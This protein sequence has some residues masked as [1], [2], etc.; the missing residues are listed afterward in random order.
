MKKIIPG[1][2]LAATLLLAACDT[3][4]TSSESSVPSSSSDSSSSLV[5]SSTSEDE[6]DPITITG[7]TTLLVGDTGT[8]T[9]DSTE[10]GL[11]WESSAP[12][13]VSVE[14][15]GAY[16]ALAKGSAV[17][18]VTA[19]SGAT[20]TLTITVNE[21]I[22]LTITGSTALTVGDKTTYSADGEGIT[23]E[24]SD[25]TILAIDEKTGAAEALDGGVV[26]IT[27]KNEEGGGTLEVEVTEL[28]TVIGEKT[29]LIGETETYTVDTDA[30]LTWKST[31]E[32]V[33]TIDAETGVATAVGM[34]TATIV[35]ES[36]EHG[37]GSY[38]VEVKN[39]HEGEEA[40]PDDGVTE[41]WPY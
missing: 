41:D 22:L 19:P 7:P 34:G 24:S 26:T 14:N 13:I 29:L 20:G 9:T 27:A 37:A 5:S 30:T 8:L 4:A 11:T 16:E 40:G 2:F 3:D 33:L 15:T 38:I 25:S 17:I 18:T 36:D 10:T 28:L 1:L 39:F 23:W 32:D 12:T 31:N 21:P 6:P 35:V